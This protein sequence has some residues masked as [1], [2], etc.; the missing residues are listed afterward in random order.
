MSVKKLFILLLLLLAT[1]QAQAQHYLFFLHNR[2]LELYGTEGV[3][4]QY[5]RVEYAEVIRWFTNQGFTVISEIR[6]ASTDAATYAR[7]VALQVDSLL[8]HGT[9]PSHITII[10]TSKGGY[11]AKL[12]CGLIANPA[13]SYIF[14]GSC[15]GRSAIN[16]VQYIGR[17]LSIYERSD[18]LGQSCAPIRKHKN[19]KPAA[20][21]E[22]ELNTGLQ[23]GF[24]YKAL[25]QWMQPAARWARHEQ[26]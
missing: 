23:H 6:P 17:I 26:M 5:G 16:G 22:I 25:P 19:N 7:K 9:A 24:L 15:N 12:A 21:Q 1:R 20:W 3:H 18:S 8:Q 14:I 11:I 13:V 2:H 4:K 10:G